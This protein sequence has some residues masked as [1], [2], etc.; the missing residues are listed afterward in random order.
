MGRPKEVRRVDSTW[1]LQ[2]S[3]R[4]ILQSQMNS[5]FWLAVETRVRNFRKMNITARSACALQAATA[6]FLS[7][8]PLL[9][10]QHEE[11]FQSLFNGRDLTGWAG[12]SNHWSVEDGAITGVTSAENPAK[13]NNFLI[14]Q[15]GETNMIVDNFELRLS[16]K[17]SGDWGNSGVQYRSKDRGKFVV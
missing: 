12:R 14:A 1:S 10:Q 2:D 3:V 4:R 6:L 15:S 11:G 13:G 5:L 17:F 8:I 16:Y 7:A 9:A